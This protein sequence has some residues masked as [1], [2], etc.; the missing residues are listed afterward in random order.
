M[1]PLERLVVT[2]ASAFDFVVIGAGPCGGAAA[3]ELARL[4][5]AGKVALIGGETR[6]PYERPPLSKATLHAP[7]ARETFL[8]GG[9][10]GLVAAGVQLFLGLTVTRIAPGEKLVEASDGRRFAY[11]RLLLATG[12]A[13]RRLQG[14]G[15]DRPEVRYLRTFEDAQALRAALHS[16]PRRVV[17]IGGGF[18]G[19]EVA[20][21]AA[22]LGHAVT[23]L[24]AEGQ[25]MSRAV[26]PLVAEAFRRKFEDEG[27]EVRLNRRAVRIDDAGA[28][29]SVVLDDGA[30]APADI[31]VVGVGSRPN[32]DLA[33]DAGLATADGVVVDVDGRTSDPDIFAAGDVARRPYALG[34]G[35]EPLRARLEAWDP[36]LN[37][38]VAVARAM[39]GADPLPLQAPWVWSDQFDW[40]LQIAGFPAPEGETVVRGQP[41]TGAFTVLHLDRNRL[42]GAVSVNAAR[43]MAQCRRLIGGAAECLPEKARDEGVRLRD[44]FAD[45]AR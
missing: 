18:I 27:V 5:G 32:V 17:V 35:L 11:G 41:E 33:V 30:L 34:P 2:E 29:C 21:T 9:A 28:G 1:S 8:F 42:V 14:P 16:G 44:A 13:E 10:E 6:S 12:A 43:D 36:A 39:A 31:V 3:M 4:S 7:D 20:A 40:N 22:R 19:L 38:G 23:V 26:P 25:L 37:Q 24:E 45:G 15:F